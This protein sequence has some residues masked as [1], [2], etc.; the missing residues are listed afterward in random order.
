[1]TVEEHQVIGGLGS[2]VAEVLGESFPVQMK[3]VG[4]KDTFAESGEYEELLSKYGLG[5][6]D[7]EKAIVGLV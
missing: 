2:A 6:K 4:V 5:E 7:I 3:R 1:M